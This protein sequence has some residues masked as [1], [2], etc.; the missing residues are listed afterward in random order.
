MQ[1]LKLPLVRTK[2]AYLDQAQEVV[3]EQF[4]MNPGTVRLMCESDQTFFG[5]N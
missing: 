2:Q 5:L 1:A 4:L 3:S